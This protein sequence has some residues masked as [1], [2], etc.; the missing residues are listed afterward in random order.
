MS[1]SKNRRILVVDDQESIHADFKK[2]L[3]SEAT[4]DHAL[5]GAW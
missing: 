5:R 4:E 1:E 3:G 2:I